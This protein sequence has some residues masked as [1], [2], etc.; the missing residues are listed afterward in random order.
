MIEDGVGSMNDIAVLG[1]LGWWN[2][3]FFL[4]DFVFVD[5]LFL[6]KEVL[7]IFIYSIVLHLVFIDDPF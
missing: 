3:F 4:L 6:A 2:L 5:F 7:D 1:L